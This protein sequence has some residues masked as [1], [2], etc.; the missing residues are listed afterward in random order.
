M[1]HLAETKLVGCQEGCQ[2]I[3]RQ[4]GLP[5]VR[6][7]GTQRAAEARVTSRRA[8]ACTYGYGLLGTETTNTRN[9]KERMPGVLCGF[10]YHC[11][12]ILT[13]YGPAPG[14]HQPHTVSYLVPGGSGS[15]HRAASCPEEQDRL[16]GLIG[17]RSLLI[18]E[19]P[20][21][22]NVGLGGK[23]MR[24]RA[25]ADA[26][27]VAGEY[28]E[29]FWRMPLHP[30]PNEVPQHTLHFSHLESRWVRISVEPV[31]CRTLSS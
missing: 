1:W 9:G 21:R 22:D 23:V 24:E 15:R 3:G 30:R 10:T 20:G 16:L 8:R 4:S 26:W 28:L 6:V 14:D 2:A 31:S 17:N 18:R 11:N 29:R 19:H 25:Q 5:A 12:G 13:L 27:G 7:C